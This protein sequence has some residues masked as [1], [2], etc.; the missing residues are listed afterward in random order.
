M[1]KQ[2]WI[3]LTGEDSP[4]P[5]DDAY[6]KER[7]M[8]QESKTSRSPHHSVASAA[9][10]AWKATAVPS[11]PRRVQKVCFLIMGLCIFLGSCVYGLSPSL[12]RHGRGHGLRGPGSAPPFVVVIDAG[13]TG[14]KVHTYCFSKGQVC[15]D[16]DANRPRS[17]QMEE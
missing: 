6:S 10:A 7:G 2:A 3:E 1:R 16:L 5:L 15:R 8:G 9:T 14:T 4:S 12:P 11:A 13:S 17:T